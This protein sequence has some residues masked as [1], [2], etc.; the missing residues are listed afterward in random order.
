MTQ[1]NKNW[2]KHRWY[3]W[4]SNPG[5]QNGVCLGLKP[6]TAE[7]KVQMNPLSYGGAH[8]NPIVPISTKV[9]NVSEEQSTLLLFK[10]ALKGLLTLQQKCS[11][12]A[13]VFP[14]KNSG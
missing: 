5:Q 9:Y 13:L 10:I 6:W 7:W 2:F 1:I 14:E 11:V 12:F 3:A 8:S 4:H